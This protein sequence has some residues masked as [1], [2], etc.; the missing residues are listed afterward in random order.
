M[1]LILL[2]VKIVTFMVIKKIF[3]LT[4]YK[5]LSYIKSIIN[6]LMFYFLVKLNSNYKRVEVKNIKWKKRGNNE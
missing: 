3:W 2:K 1:F 5:F 4:S 6:K